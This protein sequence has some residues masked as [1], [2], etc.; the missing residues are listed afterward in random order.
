M[1][2]KK[3]KEISA[4]PES[5]GLGG[6][7][8]FVLANNG[9]NSKV[10][11][12]AVKQ[13]VQPDLTGYVEKEEGKDLSSN[14]F[15]DTL[16]NKLEGISESKVWEEV[17]PENFSQIQLGDRVKFYEG[18][19]YILGKNDEY[20]LGIASPV[21]TSSYGQT[22]AIIGFDKDGNRIGDTAFDH[23][24]TEAS[25]TN[26]SQRGELNTV[27]Y[28]FPRVY[29]SVKAGD[30]LSIGGDYSPNSFPKVNSQTIVA[31][32]VF[33]DADG[34]ANDNYGQALFFDMQD[35]GSDLIDPTID[36]KIRQVHTDSED[37]KGNTK[38]LGQLAFKSD[39]PSSTNYSWVDLTYEDAKNIKVGDTIGGPLSIQGEIIDL[40]KIMV[41]EAGSTSDVSG[42]VARG[43]SFNRDKKLCVTEI[44]RT[45]SGDGYIKG[46]MNSGLDKNYI[47]PNLNDLEA[48]KNKN[49]PEVTPENIQQIKI[50]DTI[51][52]IYTWDSTDHEVSPWIVIQTGWLLSDNVPC[53]VWAL[54]AG[55]YSDHGDSITLHRWQLKSDG[56]VE[57]SSKN[58]HATQIPNKKYTDAVASNNWLGEL[59]VKIGEWYDPTAPGSGI[60]HITDY[61]SFDNKFIYGTSNPIQVSR[62]DAFITVTTAKSIVNNNAEALYKGQ[63]KLKYA[64]VINTEKNPVNCRD[65]FN[66]CSSLLKV[67]FVTPASNAVLDADKYDI[68][69]SDV[70]GMFAGCTSLTMI[71][72]IIDMRNI[73]DASDMFSDCR[74]LE[75][76]HLWRL[77]TD[78]D[79]SYT[80]IDEGVLH[81]IIDK[82]A[83]DHVIT[84]QIKESLYDSI[85]SDDGPTNIL[86]ILN[87]K[88][89][90]LAK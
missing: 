58:G 54:E 39:I 42:Y 12:N 10:S 35:T 57:E 29:K 75:V 74:N 85:V 31:R 27:R 64:P 67:M 80:K 78:I 89:I 6:S 38:T 59:W 22:L 73:T 49:Y 19:T 45:M 36:V 88:K 60:G 5:S 81:E 16:K 13:F 30:I 53:T 83:A 56:T 24:T 61:I 66:G 25:L 11:A 65:M 14:D 86:G 77:N 76:V 70:R 44:V 41:I 50:G 55:S 28:N 52:G 71:N 3:G 48:V 37:W 72:D 9:E 90:T 69:P 32:S 2:T 8:Q 21:V 33:K 26:L 18:T 1:A 79:L 51:G 15:T 40:T 17:T 34:N 46:G 43:L 84:I 4:L 20:I 7:E 47:I 68:L 62:E 87:S 82:S 63:K 23:I